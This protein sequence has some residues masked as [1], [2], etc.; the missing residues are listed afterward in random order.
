[1]TAGKASRTRFV[2]MVRLVGALLRAKEQSIT[3][4]LKARETLS[5]TPRWIYGQRSQHAEQYA[6]REHG[7]RLP[8]HQT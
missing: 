8:T 4:M 6:R 7:E 2:I 5:T 3:S 1:M